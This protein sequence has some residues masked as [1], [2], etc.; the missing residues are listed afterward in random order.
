MLN[1][2]VPQLLEIVIVYKYL[3]IF[4]VAVIE[5]PLVSIAAGFLISN[6]TLNFAVAF[7]L[8]VL[9]DLV[10]DSIYYSLGK[11]SRR[12]F[13]K[14]FG[15]YIGINEDRVMA[16]EKHFHHHHWKIIIIGKMQ[17]IGSLILVAAGIAKMPFIKFMWFNFLGT[18]PKVL[19][20]LAVGYFMGYGYQTIGYLNYLGWGSLL[21]SLI[22][23]LGYFV[24]RKY[25]SHKNE[26]D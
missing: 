17:A 8:L 7:L 22:L 9:A 5:G 6:G 12:G 25:L 14:R 10:G 4:P 24:F 26:E 16:L 13:L 19:I 2:S 23:L 11:W 18:I 3:I 20:L 1:I 15:R 21:L